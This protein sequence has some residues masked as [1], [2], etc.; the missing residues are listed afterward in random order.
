MPPGK[1]R[2]AATGRSDYSSL[3]S[4]SV[5]RSPRPQA[6]SGV[7]APRGSDN[8]AG[9]NEI[10]A[11][12]RRQADEPG[13]GSDPFAPAFQAIQSRASQGSHITPD[14]LRSWLWARPADHWPHAMMGLA[15]LGVPRAWCDWLHRLCAPGLESAQIVRVFLMALA[16]RQ[17]PGRSP[18]VLDIAGKFRRL[19]TEREF[20]RQLQQLGHK[21][22]QAAEI[23]AAVMSLND[24][25]WGEPPAARSG[26]PIAMGSDLSAC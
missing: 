2:G 24:Q 15:T 7:E 19:T 22:A 6:S 14:G 26:E 25:D 4:P 17:T 5:W 21:F 9:E 13:A 11:F 8:S 18:R 10:P 23:R 12:L 1:G 3:S 16:L 20:E